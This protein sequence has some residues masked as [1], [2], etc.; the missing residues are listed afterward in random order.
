MCSNGEGCK[1]ETSLSPANGLI[2]QQAGLCVCRQGRCMH[3]ASQGSQYPASPN[4]H[5]PTRQ[6]PGGWHCSL[7]WDE[8]CPPSSW[9]HFCSTGPSR[10]GG[11]TWLYSFL[12]KL[13]LGGNQLC[14]QYTS[15]GTETRNWSLLSIKLWARD[16]CHVVDNYS[17]IQICLQLIHLSRKQAG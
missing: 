17:C 4:R 14:S 15:W 16:I 7:Q 5:T 6:A 12:I 13:H 9:P 2:Q 1:S 11:E 3:T 8:Q 10:E